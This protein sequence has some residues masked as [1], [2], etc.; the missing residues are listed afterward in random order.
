MN[1]RNAVLR[2]RHYEHWAIATICA[3]AFFV[4]ALLISNTSTSVPNEKLV[5]YLVDICKVAPAGKTYRD[6][7]VPLLIDIS[8]DRVMRRMGN[9]Y[10]DVVDREKLY[11]LLQVLNERDKYRYIMLDVNFP[12]NVDDPFNDSLYALIDHMDR[13][14]VAACTDSNDNVNLL[15]NKLATVF[16]NTSSKVPHFTKYPIYYNSQKSMALHMY[17]D[18]NGKSVSQKQPFTWRAPVI[19]ID[20]EISTKPY[21]LGCEML[22][23]WIPWKKSFGLNLLSDTSLSD[24]HIILI[25]DFSEEGSDMHDTYAGKVSGPL[26]NYFTYLTLCDGHHRFNPIALLLLFIMIWWHCLT[27]ASGRG[28]L[29][30][31]ADNQKNCTCR[32]ILDLVDSLFGLLTV[33]LLFSLFSFIFF[34]EVYNIIIISFMLI[35]YKKFIIPVYNYFKHKQ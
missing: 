14:I 13:I 17:E 28:L 11:S 27:Y 24:N 33:P 30:R 9:A 20:R 23:D 21:Q 26:I 29:R 6:A 3:V 19:L 22:G 10:T 4:L 25:G 7:P 1:I 18:I 5:S 12:K 15:R 34:H 31:I 8:N 35:F 16:Y 32:L 2:L